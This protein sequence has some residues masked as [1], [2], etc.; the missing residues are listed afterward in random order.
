MA[1]FD[2]KNVFY[3]KF[4]SVLKKGY[5]KKLIVVAYNM[6]ERRSFRSILRGSAYDIIILLVTFF[7]TVLVDLTVAIEIGIVLAA[8]MFMK[9]MADNG[10]AVLMNDMDTNTIENKKIILSG[11]QPEVRKLLDKCRISF[12][13]GKGNFHDNFDAALAHAKEALGKMKS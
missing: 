12:L 4:F 6:S 5:T 7:L 10:E 8:L 9:R 11:V 2:I 3:P 1:K 13:V